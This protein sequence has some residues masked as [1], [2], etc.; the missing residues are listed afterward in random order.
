MG[1]LGADLESVVEGVEDVPVGSL[2]DYGN[3]SIFLAVGGVALFLEYAEEVVAFI[4][5]STIYEY[6]VVR[7]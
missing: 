1:R 5:T 6:G 7:W 2:G 3:P 4:F